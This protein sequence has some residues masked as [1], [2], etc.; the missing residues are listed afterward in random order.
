MTCDQDTG[1]C[2]NLDTP[3][4]CGSGNNG[5]ACTEGQ[6]IF[7]ASC[8]SNGNKTNVTD[9]RFWLSF[10]GDDQAFNVSVW[11]RQVGGGPDIEN[12]FYSESVTPGF[13]PNE[14]VYN[15]TLG[16]PVETDEDGNFCVSI[17][18][19][20]ATSTSPLFERSES[21][22]RESYFSC[23][24]GSRRLKSTEVSHFFG[25]N[26]HTLFSRILNLTREC[27]ILLGR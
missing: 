10:S 13:N 20:N 27:F 12:L 3:G 7:V 1:L 26:R 19:I 2:S 4:V 18:E 24:E 23:G 6:P 25:V 15:V 8:F 11:G 16:S 22:G 9:I 5:K 17:S 21:N 14:V